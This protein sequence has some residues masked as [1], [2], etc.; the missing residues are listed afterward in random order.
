MNTISNTAYFC[1]GS[2]MLD[3]ESSNPI[4]N[5]TY[6]NKFMDDRALKLFKPFINETESNLSGAVRC[7]I[8]D[9]LLRDELNKDEDINIITIGA[10]FDSRPYRLDKGHWFEIDEA[11][12]IEKKNIILPVDECKN[13]LQ[14]TSINFS[15]EALGS[16]LK[17]IDKHKKTFVIIEGVFMY[18]LE[19]QIRATLEELNTELTEYVLICDLMTKSFFEKT[20]S[21]TPEEL[22]RMGGKFVGLSNNPERIFLNNGLK[23]ITKVEL[24]KRAID[25][26]AT[27]KNNKVPNW[28]YHIAYMLFMKDLRGYTINSFVYKK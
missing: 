11:P 16:K 17:A 21:K 26:K 9:D 10:G 3:A 1:C 25:L 5:D 14:R 18:L 19:Q 15:K 13:P 20:G 7:R 23:L 4:C 6:A 28:I 8:I 2:R 24:A 27:G 22:A 12:I